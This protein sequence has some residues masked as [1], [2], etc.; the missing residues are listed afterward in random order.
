[1]CEQDFELHLTDSEI[2]QLFDEQEWMWSQ[3]YDEEQEVITSL[4]D[5]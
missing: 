5:Y 4:S 2:D 3:D 1:M